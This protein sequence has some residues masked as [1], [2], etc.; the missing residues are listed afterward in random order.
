MIVTEKKNNGTSL[1][2]THI[3]RCR[4]GSE[5]IL[6]IFSVLILLG[7]IDTAR[8]QQPGTFYAGTLAPTDTQSNWVSA[9]ADFN[10]DGKLDVVSTSY[11]SGFA[12]QLGNGD[13]TFQAPILTAFPNPGYS[14]NAPV[15]AVAVGDFNNDGAP[16][17]AAV[18]E[19]F[20]AACGYSQVGI[21]LGHDDGTF[22]LTGVS[23]LDGLDG[24]IVP[25]V[26]VA[27]FDGDGKSDVV[28]TMSCYYGSGSS[29]S[30][31]AVEVFLGNGD[32]TLG[33]PQVYPAV[34][35]GFNPVVVADLNGDGK[36]DIVAANLYSPGDTAHSSLTV[37]LNT[38][39]SF[40][41][42]P[43]AKLPFY[44]ISNIVAADF[45]SDGRMDLATSGYYSKTEIL[46]GN[47]NGTFNTLTP[48]RYATNSD[49]GLAVAD[50][51]E[52]G[53]PDLIVGGSA[54]GLDNEADILLNDGTGSFQM[55]SYPLGGWAQGSTI[56]GDFNGDG[57]TDALVV[58]SCSESSFFGDHCPDGTLGLLLGNG[59]GTTRA[60]TILSAPPGVASARAGVIATDLNGDGAKDLI[61]IANGTGGA[62]MITVYLG[63]GGGTFGAPTSTSTGAEDTSSAVIG[64]FNQDGKTD[65]V[66]LHHCVDSSCQSGAVSVLL[67]NGDGTFQRPTVY[68]TNGVFSFGIAAGDMNGDG[69]LDLAVANQY[70]D[71]TH[72]SGRVSI[73][74]GKGDGTFQSAVA[75]ESPDQADYAVAAGDFNNDGKADVALLGL[76]G[77]TDPS[78]PAAQ[79]TIF[80]VNSGGTLAQIG[81]AHDT[82]GTQGPGIGLSLAVGDV[83]SDGNQDI[84]FTT[85]CAHSACNDAPPGAN[86]S[87]GGGG[88]IGVLLGKGDGTF[89]SAQFYDVPDANFMSAAL[90]DVDGDGKLDLIARTFTGVAVLHGNGD[91]SFAPAIIYASVLQGFGPTQVAVADLNGDGT[92]DMVTT[93]HYRTTAIY[94]NGA[95]IPKVSVLPS[96]IDFG[97]LLTGT[98]STSQSVT[99]TNSGK[100]GVTFSAG[101]VTL[102]GSDPSDFMIVSDGCSGQTIAANG[103]CSVSVAF[104]PQVS[105]SE[106]ATLNFAD[107]ASDSP[108]SVALSG[109]GLAPQQVTQNIINQV[110]DLSAQG[111]INNGQDNSLVKELQKAIDMM[112]AGKINGA[113][114]NLESFI[115]EVEDLQ[116]SGVLTPSQ[117]GPLVSAANSVIAQL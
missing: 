116:S 94:F 79:E 64:D 93:S 87:P 66:V 22:T 75:T 67:G 88:G 113:I 105:G 114:G 36:P 2:P 60:A 6:A 15:R 42:L 59:D 41:E 5:I 28:V 53:K 107:N 12:V 108:Q 106:T 51:N 96:T 61:E 49:T 117:A 104:W 21:F 82:G 76:I 97:S 58:S 80:S 95:G 85:I 10:N 45:D 14:S 69:H 109:T 37:L 72:T 26:A 103:T 50:M 62:G 11:L 35:G 47:G 38:G 8:A 63:K 27:D 77:L 68:P 115:T 29:C 101:A 1:L 110:N 33:S 20:T 19:C 4:R 78:G 99:V 55:T 25:T 74:L 81:A 43:T 13:G 16:D 48:V 84:V 34:G 31:N 9:K 3:R 90:H 98:E 91:G 32:G 102:A 39:G 46:F 23:P 111:V 40:S 86:N 92:P 73:L 52:D 17:V 54:S 24:Q 89:N 30:G 65:V 83:N 44:D 18:A 70:A 71:S 100:I 7:T 112:N 56:A 57:H